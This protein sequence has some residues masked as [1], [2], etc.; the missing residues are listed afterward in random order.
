MG[1][2][3]GDVVEAREVDSP[4][5]FEVGTGTGSS[6]RSCWKI[7]SRF[8]LA[9]RGWGTC[10]WVWQHFDSSSS[11]REISCFMYVTV[12]TR[13]SSLNSFCWP[14][15]FPSALSSS[16]SFPSSRTLGGTRARRVSRAPLILVRRAFSMREWFCLRRESRADLEILPDFLGR[17]FVWV[18]DGG[19]AASW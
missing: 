1:G 15:F 7:S 6:S 14:R 13:I 16:S 5:T 10:G 12:L 4:L 17:P 9:P 19:T 18:A 11:T 8:L 3:R 2:R